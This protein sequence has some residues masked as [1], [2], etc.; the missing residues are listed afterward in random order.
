MIIEFLKKIY[1]Y[2][3]FFIYTF[4]KS[5]F[6]DSSPKYKE[7]IDC[8]IKG[9]I[10]YP[11]SDSLLLEDANSSSNI[12]IVI[13]KGIK[14]EYQGE[15]KQNDE[16]EEY[17]KVK[18]LKNKLYKK[19]YVGFIHRIQLSDNVFNEERDSISINS[20]TKIIKEAINILKSKTGFSMDQLK[21]KD[22]FFNKKCDGILYFDCSSFCS[23]I[24]N[25][26]FDFPPHKENDD[27]NDV[28]VWSTHDFFE[29]IQKSDSNFKIVD[30][31][32]LQGACLNLK[33]LQIGDLILGRASYI[34]GGVNHIMLY[35]GEGNIIHC[36]KGKYLGIET[37][38]MRNGVVIEKLNE[39]NYYTELESLKNIQKGIITKRFDVEIV[40]LRYKEKKYE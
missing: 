27:K 19:E 18:I 14:L 12:I 40:V 3:L 21:R 16:G 36:T 32:N 23:C 29:N 33:K 7:Y 8:P 22:W 37:N 24:L 34:N 25:R 17:D 39:V 30:L 28:K 15:T 20:K 11:K 6:P 4:F 10:L 31:V 38:Q 9:Q 1:D 2:I 13:N 26:T 35:A 5:I